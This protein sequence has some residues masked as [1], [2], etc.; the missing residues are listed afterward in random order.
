MGVNWSYNSEHMHVHYTL[1]V[2]LVTSIVTSI[3]ADQCTS[4]LNT[5]YTGF[6]GDQYSNI[7]CC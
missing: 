7:H 2:L 4:I 1:L 6:T 5:A 3:A